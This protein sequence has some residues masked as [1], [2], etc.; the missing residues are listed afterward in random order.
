MARHA[1]LSPACEN[2]TTQSPATRANYLRSAALAK[3]TDTMQDRNSQARTRLFSNHNQQGTLRSCFSCWNSSALPGLEKRRAHANMH[4]KVKLVDSKNTSSNFFTALQTSQTCKVIDKVSQNSKTPN[5]SKN[6]STMGVIKTCKLHATSPVPLRDQ[7]QSSVAAHIH[8]W[9]FTPPFE[10]ELI[11]QKKIKNQYCI[12][13]RRTTVIVAVTHASCIM[14]QNTHLP[15]S[16]FELMPCALEA[17]TVIK[18]FCLRLAIPTC[19]RI[20]EK[21]S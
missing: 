18:T 19:W 10:M 8:I 4:Q 11:M 2:P 14:Q 12:N 20:G 7:N 6:S 15:N 5:Q 1:T 17:Q 3:A 9:N 16:F 13:A 21:K